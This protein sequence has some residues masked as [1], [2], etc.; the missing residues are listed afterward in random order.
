MPRTETNSCVAMQASHAHQK[1]N[2]NSQNLSKTTG[3]LEDCK[4][5]AYQKAQHGAASRESADGRHSHHTGHQQPN[6][7]NESLCAVRDW[8]QW[9]LAD[10]TLQQ[11]VHL[12]REKV[13]CELV[14]IAASGQQQLHPTQRRMKSELVN[15][16]AASVQQQIHPSPETD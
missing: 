12:H 11:Q 5:L 9:Q 13:A 15:M 14:S 8:R 7:L 1:P 6:G 16:S 10:Q 4:K 3:M 2:I